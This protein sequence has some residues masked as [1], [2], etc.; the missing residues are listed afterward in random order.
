MEGLNVFEKHVVV[1]LM[2][3]SN[4][5]MFMLWNLTCSCYGV[6][7]K[8]LKL[9]TK[10]VIFLCL[11]QRCVQTLEYDASGQN[12]NH[13]S[14]IAMLIPNGTLKLDVRLNNIQVLN[15]RE[16]AHLHNLDILILNENQLSFL[17]S[18]CLENTKITQLYISQNVLKMFPNLTA[19]SAT[20]T[21]LDLSTNSINDIPCDSI[22]ALPKLKTLNL[23]YNLIITVPGSC[24]PVPLSLK[25]LDLKGNNISIVTNTSFLGMTTTLMKVYFSQYSLKG[26]GDA[27]ISQL[28]HRTVHLHMDSGDLTDDDLVC[29]KHK[30]DMYYITS[31]RITSNNLETIP[32][33]HGNSSRILITLDLQ[34]NKITVVPLHVLD[35]LSS[36]KSLIINNNQLSHLPELT[37]LTNHPLLILSVFENDIQNVSLAGLTSLEELNA[38]S[39]LI[40]SCELFP[41]TIKMIRLQRNNLKELDVNMLLKLERLDLERNQ[42][43]CVYGHLNSSSKLNKI[44]LSHNALSNCSLELL[45]QI[46]NIKV[47]KIQN[48]NLR[49]FPN[50]TLS[51]DT[52]SE[53]ALSS[54]ELKEI[55]PELLQGFSHLQKLVL[56]NNALTFL[57][58][59]TASPLKV[60]SA[61]RNQLQLFPKLSGAMNTTLKELNLQY[62]KIQLVCYEDIYMLRAL[63]HIRLFNNQIQY[64]TSYIVTPLIE[65]IE[66]NSN[67]FVCDCHMAWLKNASA[68]ILSQFPCEA[69]TSL[70][71]YNWSSIS[72]ESLMEDCPSE[73]L[74]A[75]TQISTSILTS[76]DRIEDTSMY[77]LLNSNTMSAFI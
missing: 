43:T 39:N 65:S 4:L 21:H 3:L 54:N 1:Y 69:P 12:L 73:S 9:Y 28:P 5:K 70:G 59:M 75:V 66:L 19:V 48:S 74:C 32:L 2:E 38:N 6:S 41:S 29:F 72:T 26:S 46:H 56:T 64:I 55:R 22:Q 37:S 8:M 40:S 45:S 34:Y 57:P 62:N 10:M 33:L 31:L 20:L 50:I 11:F 15:D 18:T 67:M 49:D 61:N 16:L 14:D 23:E 17:S 76:T 47:L 53:I 42:I 63:Q 51:F 60:L 71:G 25:N 68:V 77:L 24:Q 58:Q 30:S 27:F 44:Q 35:N 13:L 52:I 36:L 7:L